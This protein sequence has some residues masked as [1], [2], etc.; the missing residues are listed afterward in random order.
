[1]EETK[2]KAA[3][4]R[5]VL[6]RRDAL[7]VERRIEASLRIAEH[8]GRALSFQPGTIVSGFMPIR[9]EP[10]TRPLM[11]TLADRGARLSLPVVVDR[12][13]IVFRELERGA[14]LVDSGFGTV[15][16]GPEAKVTHPELMLVPLAAFDGRGNR[17]GY[18]AGHYDRAVARLIADGFT[19]RLVGVAFDLQEIET[20]PFEDHDRPLDAIL[21][22]SGLRSFAARL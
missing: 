6:Q 17:I 20:V 2:D 12:Q 14:P 3:L 10:D 8:G 15:G 1:M 7:P 4:R 11:A 13:T 21:T 5:E 18:G 9:S 19:P 22:E 16:P